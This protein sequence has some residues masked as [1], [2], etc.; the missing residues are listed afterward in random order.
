[1]REIISLHGVIK[2]F[3]YR[4]KY[5]VEKEAAWSRGRKKE[6]REPG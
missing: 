6:Y 2:N 3:D 4:I 1:M 5:K